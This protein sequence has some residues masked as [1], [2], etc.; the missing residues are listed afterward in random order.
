M[1]VLPVPQRLTP[2]PT[3]ASASRVI[4]AVPI[5]G[6]VVG[7]A[8]AAVA[9]VAT[10]ARLHGLLAGVAA[11]SASALLTRGM[12]LDALA[13]CADG[14]GTYGSPE[15]A[16][17]VMRQGT[18]G[19]FGAAALVLV[20]L[21]EVAAVA[22]LADARRWPA[23]AVA[24]AAARVA[25]VIGCRRGWAPA[26]RDGFGALTADTQHP[27]TVASWCVIACAAAVPA[28]PWAWQGPAA[29]AMALAI[30]TLAMRH[31]VR[32]FAGASGDVFGLG[33]ETAT[34]VAM[35]GL[36]VTP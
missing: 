2:A 28:T 13:D 36:C 29:V 1:T 26:N 10:S 21:A 8:V 14:L 32:R 12:H 27:A 9:W 33:I 19:A 22:T 31:C 25:A 5:A 34:L 20:L 17:E 15:R 4:A 11:V 7:I 3:R 35:V 30:A 6:V 24:V 16:R 18:I 23:I